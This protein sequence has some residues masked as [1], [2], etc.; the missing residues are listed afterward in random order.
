MVGTESQVR[1]TYDSN[2]LD[3]QNK[4]VERQKQ[5]IKTAETKTGGGLDRMVC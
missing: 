2:C 3:M 1:D 4:K 5:G